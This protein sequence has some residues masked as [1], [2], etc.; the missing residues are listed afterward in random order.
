M[1]DTVER[2][3]S[4]ERRV[5]R[6]AA[7]AVL[8]HE[9][10]RTVGSVMP[11]AA[12]VPPVPP[13][14]CVPSHPPVPLT[15][16]TSR[17]EILQAERQARQ[18][19]IMAL[20]R[21][22]ITV[23]EI[24][25]SS[26]CPPMAQRSWCQEHLF[27]DPR[28]PTCVDLPLLRSDSSRSALCVTLVSAKTSVTAINGTR[29]CGSASYVTLVFAET[30]VTAPRVTWPL[31]VSVIP[32]AMLAAPLSFHGARRCTRRRRADQERN[33]A[34][35][36]CT[37][38]VRPVAVDLRLLM[39]HARAEPAARARGLSGGRPGRYGWQPARNWAMRAGS[40]AMRS[41]LVKG[42]WRAGRRPDAI[43]HWI[44]RRPTPSRRAKPPTVQSPST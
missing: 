31:R 30:S 25:R 27:L 34:A 9:D 33:P 32:L 5:L 3:L 36:R 1:A 11:P 39:G 8:A 14:P 28:A 10:E 18:E 41:C 12:D 7:D 40:S 16:G 4:R 15:R 13:A 23:S 44:Q 17:Q 37:A 42:C 20:H 35:G 24:T 26:K 21:Q 19:E 2:V 43:C 6:E 38:P 22:G 29:P